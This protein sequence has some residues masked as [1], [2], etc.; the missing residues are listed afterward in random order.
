[1]P[2]RWAERLLPWVGAL[3]L[4]MGTLQATLWG[5]RGSVNGA[6]LRLLGTGLLMGVG[7][8]GLVARGR[9]G[10]RRWLYVALGIG[11]GL[12]GYWALLR[13]PIQVV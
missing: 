8:L 13:P 6:E 3:L 7:G 10:A 12:F 5:A 4:A 2:R 9:G 11:L 1:M